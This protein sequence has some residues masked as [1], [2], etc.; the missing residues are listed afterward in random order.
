MHTY[1]HNMH[2]DMHID[3]VYVHVYYVHAYR[4]IKYIKKSICTIMHMYIYIVNNSRFTPRDVII[5]NITATTNP[6]LKRGY[7]KAHKVQKDG[8]SEVIVEVR[9]VSEVRVIKLEMKNI[10]VEMS[11]Q[12]RNEKHKSRNE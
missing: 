2:I 9:E 7:P 3:T 10:K 6:R 1:I 5:L 12:I 8:I 4:Q 11:H